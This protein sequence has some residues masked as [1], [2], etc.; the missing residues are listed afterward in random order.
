MK[1]GPGE[2][3][4]KC[5]YCFG[6]FDQEE[7]IFRANKGFSKNELSSAD[8]GLGG[9][10]AGHGNSGEDDPRNLFRMFDSEHSGGQ[11]K[12]LDQKL[13][14][15][16]K[17]R[18]GSSGYVNADTHW[19]YP[20][21]DPSDPSFTEM[22]SFEPKGAFIP[23]GD[24]FV[25]DADGFI[26]RVLDKHS[27]GTLTSMTRLCPHCHNPLPLADYGKYPVKFISVVGITGSG[28]TVFLNQLLTNFSEIVEGTDYYVGPNNL[29][30]VGVPVAQG[31]PLPASTDDKIMRRPF[32]VS[33]MKRNAS[34]D[35]DD[36][37]LTI[38]F[39]DIAGE[40]CV[41]RDG[42]PDTARAQSTIGYFISACD[43]LVFLLDPE[44]IPTFAGEH[45]RD[46][47]IAN[48]V[49][50]MNTIRSN[51]NPAQPN[52]NEIPV[53]VC[54]AKSDKL[55]KSPAI[56][57]ENPIFSYSNRG[58]YG[59]D[60]EENQEIDQFLRTFLSKNA[61]NV[62]AP[63]ASFPRRSHFAVSA[64]TCGVESRFEKYRNMYI[65]DEE[66]EQRFHYLRRWVSGWNGRSAEEREMYKECPVLR[67]DGSRIEFPYT[68][69]IDKKT[70][71]GIVTEIRADSETGKSI[72]LSLW[73]VVADVNLVG[74]PVAAPA[75]RRIGDP[76]KWILWQ[77]ELIGPYFI[78][79]VVG[80]KPF[81]M[82]ERKWAQQCEEI[83][84][85]NEYNRQLFYGTITEGN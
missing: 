60:R 61:H 72:H 56:P 57:R 48:V 54:I 65:L 19:D 15:F 8:T 46:S 44:Q 74:Y 27:D 29:E 33:L 25:R 70:A 7:T 9:L 68:T 13:I 24:G 3:R 28:K 17:E 78:P 63:L 30:T 1:V 58:V 75:P 79:T 73:D 76:L 23:D 10:L 5:P 66:N 47:N 16:W 53:A 31:S 55:R 49:N 2:Y 81:L 38:V 35:D 14:D 85:S 62:V 6:E 11:N 20:H 18:G 43:A 41:N 34:P 40:N 22:I 52:W 39:Y 51:M 4:I 77:L 83:A 71:D 80:N 32:A 67:S 37:G 64:I 42:S 84:V 69:S 21:I 45:V 50:V 82:S 12:K 36:A 26:K 59:Y